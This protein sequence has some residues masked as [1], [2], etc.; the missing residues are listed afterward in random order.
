MNKDLYNM[1]FK[2]KSFHTFK[3]HKLKRYYSLDYQISK[4]E[5]EDIL[6]AFNLFDTLYPDIKVKIRIADNNETT[7]NRGQEKVI[8]LY[9]EIKDNYLMNIGYIGQQLDL[10]LA[11]KNIGTLWFGLNKAKMADY[12]GLKYVIMIAICKV[13]EDSF[14][15]DMYKSRRRELKDIWKGNQL[16]DIGNII[17][18][19][20][21]AC[22]SQP[23][24]IENKDNTLYV[25]RYVSPIKKW[26]MPLAGLL[27]FNHIDIGI[28]ICFL[29]LCLLHNNISYTKELFIDDKNN[30]LN[31][32]AKYNLN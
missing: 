7:C 17:R 26:V 27:H 21:S 2:R 15:K 18:F 6:N 25:Y 19:A 20:P 22:N 29:E 9:S 24:F 28:F 4:E 31:L 8:L 5:Y 16:L 32:V 13:P 11:S 14:R 23:W 1:I 30:E 12:E 10:Y 3:N